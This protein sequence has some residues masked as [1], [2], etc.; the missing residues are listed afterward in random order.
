MRL[1]WDFALRFVETTISPKDEAV[2]RARYLLYETTMTHDDPHQIA[3]D[4][5]QQHGLDGALSIAINSATVAND[6]YALSVWR[7]VK[8]ILRLKSTA[9]YPD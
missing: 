3:D 8:G 7:E 5:I 6:N 1:T 4:L 2:G 9:A